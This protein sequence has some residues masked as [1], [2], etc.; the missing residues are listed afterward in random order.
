MSNG[1]IVAITAAAEEERQ[2]DLLEQEEER[3]TPY[4]PDDLNDDWEFKIVR[5]GTGA[6]RKPEAL[7]KVIE[8]E[9][10]AGWVML[11]KIDDSRIRFKRPRSARTKDAFLPDDVD[12]YRTQYDGYATQQMTLK[13]VILGLV[14]FL[15]L[16]VAA[17]FLAGDTASIAE[18]TTIPIVLPL[19]L[20]IMGFVVVVW[21][22]RRP[23]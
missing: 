17:F 20:I 2:R 11:E 19:I 5:S 18:L 21:K 10:Q 13:G 3:M 9:T 1:A 8:E 12:P 4:T 15:G 23:R 7:N 6:F 22:M 16:G 14:L